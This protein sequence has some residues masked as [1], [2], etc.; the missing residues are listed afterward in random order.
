[1]HPRMSKCKA[2][3]FCGEFKNDVKVQAFSNVIEDDPKK[4]DEIILFGLIDAVRENNL[5]FEPLSA[6]TSR[7]I[8]ERAKSE[9]KEI[10]HI[11]RT[12][13]L[14]KFHFQELGIGPLLGSGG[15]SNV[16][17]IAYINP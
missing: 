16:F 8:V 7:K 1:M 4:N 6:S 13:M 9:I 15:F 17:E 2:R 3:C 14:A 12:Q 10:S 11:C 5:D